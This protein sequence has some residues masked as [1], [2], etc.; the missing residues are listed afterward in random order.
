MSPTAGLK[1][2]AILENTRR[3][4]AIEL[5][6]AA[7]GLDLRDPL[8]CSKGT[9]AAYLKIRER[10][11]MVKEDRPISPLIETVA[12]MISDGSI[13]RAVELSVHVLR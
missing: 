11:P 13:L 8:K 9:R 6:C 2:K 10:V 5:I 3:V 1:A 7:Q 12:D 4:L